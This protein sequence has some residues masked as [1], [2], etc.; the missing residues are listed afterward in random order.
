[1][2]VLKYAVPYK[3]VVIIISSYKLFTA[4]EYNIT[5]VRQTHKI[6]FNATFTRI[7]QANHSK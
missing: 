6:L 2:E 4:S 5:H 7:K 1:M 3:T